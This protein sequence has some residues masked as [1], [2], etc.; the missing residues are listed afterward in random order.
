LW[1]PAALAAKTAGTYITYVAEETAAPKP[2]DGV[3]CS[4]DEVE[5]EIT[6]NGAQNANRTFTILLF[7]G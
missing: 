3:P 6:T 2:L 4:N 5:I 1:N 7:L